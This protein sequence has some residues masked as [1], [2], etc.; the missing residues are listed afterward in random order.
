MTVNSQQVASI[1]R[2]VVALAA[3]VMGAL[4]AALPSI[5]LPTGVSAALAAVGGVILAIEHYV[6]DPSTGTTPP[7]V[8]HQTLP[9]SAPPPVVTPITPP[10][11]APPPPANG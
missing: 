11:V 2:Q 3:V 5:Q 10:T 7:V 1:F 4:T 6:S 9:P 8:V